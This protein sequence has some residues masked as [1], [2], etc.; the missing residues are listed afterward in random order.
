MNILAGAEKLQ[1][2]LALA[3]EAGCRLEQDSSQLKQSLQRVEL[4]LNAAHEEQRRLR[5]LVGYC[6]VHVRVQYY[7]R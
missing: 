5:E 3:K 2:E 4:E 7:V 1:N 6:T